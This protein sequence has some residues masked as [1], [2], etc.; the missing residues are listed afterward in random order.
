MITRGLGNMPPS[1]ESPPI[2]IYHDNN[3]ATTNADERRP[4]AH[5]VLRAASPLLAPEK[6]WQVLKL[7]GKGHK[8]SGSGAMQHAKLFLLR[9]GPAAG[10]GGGGG[11][12]GNGFLRVVI[13]SVNLYWC[14]H[15][16]G[17]CHVNLR[18]LGWGIFIHSPTNSVM[19]LLTYI[20]PTTS[21][22]CLLQPVGAFA[23]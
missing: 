18:W 17:G 20:Y 10:D 4:S 2:L 5:S 21:L 6:Q 22:N 16:F 3:D 12:G 1:L 7:Q 9:F 14:A 23:R 15:R 11:G 13:G 19:H 8:G